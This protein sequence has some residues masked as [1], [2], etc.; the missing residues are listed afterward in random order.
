M[1]LLGSEL[2]GGGDPAPLVRL[3]GEAGFV[4]IALAP[5]CSRSRAVDL[6][7]A[8]A[9]AGLAVPVA[10]AP[11]L[12]TVPLPP[13]KR[14]PFLASVDDPE[15]RRAAVDL[16]DK[17]LA[18]AVPLGV[19]LFTVSFGD[20]PLGVAPTEVRRRFQRREMD[21]DEPGATL[22][23]AAFSERRAR[24]PGILDACRFSLD[25]L[26]PLAERAGVV[27]AIEVSGGPWGAPTP[28]EVAV[29]LEEYR[30]APLGVVWDDARLHVL[31]NLGAAPQKERAL[32]LAAATRLRRA[33]EAVGLDVGFLPGQGDSGHASVGISPP[34]S[35][36]IVVSGRPDSTLD[37]LRRARALATPR[38][39]PKKPPAE[40]GGRGA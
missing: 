27:V 20:I 24:S 21:E 11:L 3:A 12:D 32:Q 40:S 36:P 2:R 22:L 19:G 30:E 34:S 26:V 37:E 8:A 13:G 7:T 17:A 28:R 9:A 38:E 16:F 29:L 10:A 23:A 14:L 35:A 18:A 25:L 5:W 39:E 4:G 31:W 6:A 15:E 33:N 1:I